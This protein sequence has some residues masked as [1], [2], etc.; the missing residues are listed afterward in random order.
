MTAKNILGITVATE[1]NWDSLHGEF[2][3]SNNETGKINEDGTVFYD[4]EGLAQYLFTSKSDAFEYL[5]NSVE[6]L[7]KHSYY[8]GSRE[9]HPTLDGWCKRMGIG[10]QE[11][12]EDGSSVWSA[13]KHIN[14]KEIIEQDKFNYMMLSRLS[15]DAVQF[16]SEDSFSYRKV[17][18][19]WAGNIDEQIKEMKKIYN[20]ITIKPEWLTMDEINAYENKMKALIET[21]NTTKYY[22]IKY[23]VGKVKY[24]IS[25]H[26]GIKTHKDGSPFSDIEFF[27]N[28]K[29]LNAFE[30]ELL[31]DGYVYK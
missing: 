7:C 26:D 1:E 13:W 6:V 18:N 31:K 23:N 2:C 16:L 10:I 11:E 17:K 20:M 27:S 19:L 4:S 15:N 3:F 5:F 28:K 30:K 9:D 8:I 24:L 12:E 21:S 14:D 22:N 29:K 25:Y